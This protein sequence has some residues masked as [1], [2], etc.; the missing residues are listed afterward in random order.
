M[1]GSTPPP[2]AQIDK[3][4]E[5]TAV[6]TEESMSGKTTKVYLAGPLGF[7]D[8]GRLYHEQVISV[9]LRAEGFDLLDP[10]PPAGKKIGGVQQ[11]VLKGRM[12][13]EALRRVNYEVGA[14]NDAMIAKCDCVLAVLDG[15]DVDSGTASEVGYAKALA[16]PIIGLR[17]DLRM[18]ADNLATA[19]NLQ[20]A[21]F[22]LSS[23]GAI[24]KTLDD[25]VRALRMVVS[26]GSS[27]AG[28]SE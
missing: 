8:A 9:R 25:A 17:S 16:K 10:W 6:V 24:V 4:S 26:L 3:P 11:S 14:D 15:S 13:E 27:D 5:R 18:T 22:V 28:H 21:Y 19:I 7:T 23:G 2:T 12:L 20:V 1:F